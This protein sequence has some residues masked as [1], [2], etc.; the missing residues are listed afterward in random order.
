MALTFSIDSIMSRSSPKHNKYT[1]LILTP[2][3]PKFNP[4]AITLTPPTPTLTSD[5][6]NFSPSSVSPDHHHRCGHKLNDIPLSPESDRAETTFDA[7]QSGSVDGSRDWSDRSD[8]QSGSADGSRDWLD[9]SDHQSGRTD[10]SREWL[11]RSDRDSPL[12]QTEPRDY[13]LISPDQKYDTLKE[14]Q[15]NNLVKEESFQQHS[16][17]NTE[18]E[19]HLSNTPPISPNYRVKDRSSPGTVSSSTPSYDRGAVPSPSHAFV[20]YS[21]DLHGNQREV[22]GNQRGKARGHPYIPN[23]YR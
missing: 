21:R 16:S 5:C 11:D 10:G 17:S 1:P 7:S 18:R 2:P 20:K 14:E 4:A 23:V 3:T 19:R 8:H 15:R 13:R 9:R 12:S 6:K 22:H